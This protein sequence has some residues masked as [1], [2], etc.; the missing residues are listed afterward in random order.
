MR[1]PRNNESSFE[2][3]KDWGK[4]WSEVISLSFSCLVPQARKQAG[5]NV[6]INVD[7]IAAKSGRNG[8]NFAA[9]LNH[10]HLAEFLATI[11]CRLPPTQLFF[12]LQSCWCSNKEVFAIHFT[13]FA[14]VP[15]C[16]RN[17]NKQSSSK[18]A[19][20]LETWWFG[21]RGW[22]L[23]KYAMARYPSQVTA[24]IIS[25]KCD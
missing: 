22:I 24:G 21:G 23:E 8:G 17:Y 2:R 5:G 12:A 3:E 9:E 15:M 7:R 18:Y 13:Y 10:H 14:R 1:T 4:V 11:R 20:K 6:K 19:N 16:R 25:S